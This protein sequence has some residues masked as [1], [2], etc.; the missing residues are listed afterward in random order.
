MAD[1]LRIIPV[2]PSLGARVEG[3]DLGHDLPEETIFEIRQALLK[4][5]VL[6]FEDQSLSPIEQRDF[7]ARFGSLHVHPLRPSAPGVPEVLVMGAQP[8]SESDNG[9]WRSDVTFIEAPPMGSVL[10]AHEVPRQGGDT[11]WSSMRAAY[12]ALSLPMQRFL[13]GLDAEHDFTRSYPQTSFASAGTGMERFAWARR[14]HPPVKHPVVRTHPETHLDGLFVNS[15]FT[16]RI[17]GLNENESAKLLE[18][19]REHIQQP[20]FL[21]RWKW[22]PGTVAFWDNRVTQHYTVNDYLPH[23]R[24]MRRVTILGDRPFNRARLPRELAAE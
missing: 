16:S 15:G 20:E 21:V 1:K 2:S 18:M 11:I 6:F 17:L 19:L 23:R 12:N 22:K 10:Y 5:E 3:A 14:E 13:S 24:I 4:H 7:A 9:I 8:G